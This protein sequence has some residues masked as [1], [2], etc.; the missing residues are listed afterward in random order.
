MYNWWGLL[1]VGETVHVEG[2]AESTWNISVPSLQ[3]HCELK[4]YL[5]HKVFIKNNLNERRET[6]RLLI[7]VLL[8]LS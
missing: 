8:Q 3:F 4:I 7:E 5:K 2:W 6:Q 1:R